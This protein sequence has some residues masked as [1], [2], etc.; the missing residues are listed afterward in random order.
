[1]PDFTKAAIAFQLTMEGNW[2]TAVAFLGDDKLAA[3][4]GDGRIFLWN[5]AQPPAEPTED[6]KKDNELKDRAADILPQRQLEGHANGVTRLIAAEGGKLLV[7]AS[8]DH[9]IGLWNPD[10][11]P[12]GKKEAVL[13]W[14]QRRRRVKR[15]KS[16]EQE[17]LSAPGIE[18]ETVA[19]QARLEGHAD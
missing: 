3:G 15:D 19:P 14:H 4:D 5:L 6:Q 8:L 9:T 7:S 2:P 13:D 12:T 18:V 1:M 10:A 16:N 11:S 17:I